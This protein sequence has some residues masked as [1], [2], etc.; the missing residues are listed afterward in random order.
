ME[1]NP[2][3]TDKLYEDIFIKLQ[4]GELE[5]APMMADPAQWR[6]VIRAL[7]H[8]AWQATA[9]PEIVEISLQSLTLP[10]AQAAELGVE[11]GPFVRW[12]IKDH[13]PGMSAE[14]SGR[15]FEPF[16]STRAKKESLGLGLTIAH[17]VTRLHGGQIE[18]QSGEGA[19]TTVRIWLPKVAPGK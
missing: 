14:V 2:G 9:S 18:I 5:E 12:E 11:P 13:G 19:G 1:Q 17:S 15:A 10:A 16:F 3:M 4:T 8:N 7:L 6:K